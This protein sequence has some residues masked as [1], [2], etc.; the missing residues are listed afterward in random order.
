MN[1]TVVGGVFFARLGTYAEYVE[2]NGDV[3]TALEPRRGPRGR[4]QGPGGR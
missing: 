4:T 1:R 2:Y 3:K